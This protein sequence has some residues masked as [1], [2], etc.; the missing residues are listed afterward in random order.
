MPNENKVMINGKPATPIKKIRL[1]DL[2]SEKEIEQLV[3]AGHV[4]NVPGLREK[5]QRGGAAKKE[6]IKNG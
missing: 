5:L 1:K 3:R 2:L 6:E 4:D